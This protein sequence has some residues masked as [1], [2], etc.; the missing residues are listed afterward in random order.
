[1]NPVH[2]IQIIVTLVMKTDLTLHTVLVLKVSILN[3]KAENVL[4]VTID[5]QLAE[6]FLII[7][8]LNV[9]NVPLIVLLLLL[10]IVQLDIM[11]SL[12]KL[13]VNLVLLNVIPVTSMVVSPVLST[14]SIQENVNAE[15][16]CMKMPTKNVRL[17]LITV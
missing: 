11:I 15:T 8:I 17:V 9:N 4:N 6:L 7:A 10:V 13:I 3:L 2:N 5:V 16:E 1:V 12:I 14:E